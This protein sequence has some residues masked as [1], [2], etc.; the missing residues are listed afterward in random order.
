M[1]RLIVFTALGMSVHEASSDD[2]PSNI[3][4]RLLRSSLIRASALLGQ[5]LVAPLPLQHKLLSACLS[6]IS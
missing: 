4:G 2:T 5:I 1:I 6:R 3:R